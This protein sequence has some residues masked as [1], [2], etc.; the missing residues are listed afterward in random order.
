M[1]PV[2]WCPLVLGVST[3]SCAES[4]WL[5]PPDT[6]TVGQ[7]LGATLALA[8]TASVVQDALFRGTNDCHEAARACDGEGNCV[9][10]V[11]VSVETRCGFP[12][13]GVATG[14]I[15]ASVTS[16]QSLVSF[17]FVDFRQVRVDGRV[18][19]LR[20]ASGFVA[21]DGAAIAEKKAALSSAGADSPGGV[22]E[23]ALAV[24]FLDIDVDLVG[25][26][27]RVDEWVVFVDRRG[28]P[29]EFGDDAYWIAGQRVTGAAAGGEAA[30]QVALFE[31]RCRTNPVLGFVQLAQVDEASVDGLSFLLFADE[32]RGDGFVALSLGPHALAS[33]RRVPIDLLGPSAPGTSGGG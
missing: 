21:I 2:R 33:G 19:P 14:T 24:V 28:T 25:Q 15:L 32:C 1:C 26:G 18:L 4:P 6:R 27:A 10:Q 12:F 30:Q 31:P 23:E 29:S 20:S 7:T 17:G 11:R 5:E 8:Y 13:P 22:P 3:S 9:A 16:V